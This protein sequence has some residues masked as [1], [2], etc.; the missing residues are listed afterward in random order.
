VRTNS[1]LTAPFAESS[2][3]EEKGFMSSLSM[4]PRKDPS[5]SRPSAALETAPEF[6]VTKSTYPEPLS[7]G[8]RSFLANPLMLS[9]SVL[10]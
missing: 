8:T 6:R 10:R 3:D 4:V 5:R 9:A 1:W 2:T 7:T